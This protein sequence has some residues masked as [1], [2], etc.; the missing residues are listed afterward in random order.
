MIWVA[1]VFYIFAA[2]S[3]VNLPIPANFFGSI[4]S[5]SFTIERLMVLGKFKANQFNPQPICHWDGV[6]LVRVTK[7]TDTLRRVEH[8]GSAGVADSV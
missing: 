4:E 6:F 1:V 3:F 8:G 5:F 7:E 2:S